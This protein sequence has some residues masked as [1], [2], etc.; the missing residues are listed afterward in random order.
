MGIGPETA[1][2]MPLF[3]GSQP[4]GCHKNG[5]FAEGHAPF[6]AVSQTP[7]PLFGQFAGWECRL[8]DGPPGEFTTRLEPL[9][10]SLDG[11]SRLDSAAGEHRPRA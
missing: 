6:W 1:K 10:P 7:M 4:V 9:L 5:L 11:G 8:L 2:S 3:G